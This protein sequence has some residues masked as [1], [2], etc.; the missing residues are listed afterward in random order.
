MNKAEFLTELEQHLQALPDQEKAK[1][2][3]YYFEIIDDRM[4]CGATEEEAV[5]ACGNITGIAEQIIMDTPL[6][7]L[8]RQKSKTRRKMRGWEIALLCIGS[9]VWFSLM[10]AAFCVLIAL[11]A[12]LW[13]VVISIFAVSGAFGGTVIGLSALAIL[14]MVQGQFFPALLVFGCALILAGLMLLF[15]LL[16]KYAAKGTVWLHK[17]TFRGVKRCFIRKET[18]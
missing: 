3:E 10:V 7:K 17:I 18:K 4:D 11:S 16:G 9:P 8:V 1:A 5:A 12:A 2:L 6:T 13:A 15:F 14:Y